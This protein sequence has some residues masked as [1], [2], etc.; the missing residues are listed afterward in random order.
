MAL[1]EKYPQGT[2]TDLETTPFDSVQDV[3]FW[4]IKAQDARNEGARF[5]AGQ[6]L[7]P[8]PC[9]PIDILRVLDRLYRNRRLIR[10]HLLVLRHYGRRGFAPDPMRVKEERAYKIWAE[11]LERMEPVLE[12]KGIVCKMQRTPSENWQQKSFVLQGGRIK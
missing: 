12:R 9:E 5:S 7:V 11:A 1:K 6:G 2:Y 4:F 10:D 8:R 3:W